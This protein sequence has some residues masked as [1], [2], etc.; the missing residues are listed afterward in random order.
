[1]D[2][3]EGDRVQELKQNLSLKIA[4]SKNLLDELEDLLADSKKLSNG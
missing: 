1:M 4:E 3:P 2:H